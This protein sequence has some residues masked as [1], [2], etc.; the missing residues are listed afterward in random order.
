M[1]SV[2]VV[3]KEGHVR[4]AGA[5]NVNTR[6]TLEDAVDAFDVEELFDEVLVSERAIDDCVAIRFAVNE[7]K[8]SQRSNVQR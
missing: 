5:S 6:P 1:T 4:F 8:S 7:V 3:D 2:S